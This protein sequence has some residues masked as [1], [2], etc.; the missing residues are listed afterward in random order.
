MSAFARQ[1][2]IHHSSVSL[3]ES[4]KQ[5]PSRTVLLL[6]HSLSNYPEERAVI[7]EALGATAP[8]DLA[9]KEKALQSRIAE[10]TVQLDGMRSDLGLASWDR[11]RGLVHEVAGAG[12]V[13]LWLI[14]ILTLW[15][16]YRNDAVARLEFDEIVSVLRDQLRRHEGEARK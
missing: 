2:G 1:L 5:R 3:Y 11:F 16:Q 14:E 8:G 12:R 4:G 10:A 15:I 7:E 13:P 6:V 9:V